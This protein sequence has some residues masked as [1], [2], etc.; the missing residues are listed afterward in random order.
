MRTVQPPADRCVATS[1]S[2]MHRP[3]QLHHHEPSP[4]ASVVSVIGDL[5][6]ASAA[7]FKQV[8]GDLMGTGVRHL[9]VDLGETAFIDSSGLGAVLWADRRLHAVGGDLEITNADRNVA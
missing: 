3:F 6:L 7:A 5:D 9:A 2:A 8:V 1:E 4:D